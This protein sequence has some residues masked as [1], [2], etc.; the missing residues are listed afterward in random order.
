MD[1]NQWIR[2]P[3]GDGAASRV[4]MAGCRSVLA[5]VPTITAGHRLNDVLPLLEADHRVQTVFTVPQTTDSWHGV[6]DY[7][8]GLGGLVMPWHQAIRHTFDLVL[9]ASH[10]EIDRVHGKVMIL[11]HGAG[12]LMSR[13]LSRKAGGATM[14]TTGLDRELLTFRGRVIPS[15]IA[16]THES[17]LEALRESCPEAVHT[18]VIAGDICLDRILAGLPLREHYRRALGISEDQKLITVSSTWS[19]ES[20]FGHCFELYRKL[21]DELAD[22][23]YRLA[24]VL[25]PNVW[26]VHGQWQVRTW[27]ADCLRAG[28]LV[29]PPEQ[30]WEATMV[31]SDLVVGDRGSTTMYA[32]AIGKPVL[33]ATFPDDNVWSGSLADALA[34]GTARLDHN[35]MLAPQLEKLIGQPVETGSELAGLISSR[36]A[37]AAPILRSAMYRLL[38]LSEPARQVPVSPVALP[39]PLAP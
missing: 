36:P 38:G 32:A 13:R 31:A 34:R 33:L 14:P 9:T 5:M 30:G 24:A 17:E 35:S 1:A 27:L 15:V 16:L 22:E 39:R 21:R 25:H 10:R 11:P 12:N 7:V 4:T 23:R 19:P 29:I 3:V 18:A 6:E 8:R 37:A 26:A 28:L 2:G 20:T